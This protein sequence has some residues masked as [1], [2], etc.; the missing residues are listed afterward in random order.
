MNT[1]LR[2]FV[3]ELSEL[4]TKGLSWVHPVT[5][6]QMISY[7]CAPVCSVDAVARAMLQNIKQY[8]GTYGCSLCEQPGKTCKQSSI[9]HSHIYPPSDTFVLRDGT[10]CKNRLL[11][12]SRLEKL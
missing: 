5:G 7:I 8:N 4:F 10:K 1:F 9:A 6:R 3:A 2:P 11:K 12:L